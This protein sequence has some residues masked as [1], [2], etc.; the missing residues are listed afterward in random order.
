[1]YY[2]KPD[3]TFSPDANVDFIRTEIQKLRW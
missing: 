1:L 3:L 2:L